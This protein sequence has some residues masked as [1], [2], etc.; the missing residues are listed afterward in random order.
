MQHSIDAESVDTH[1]LYHRISLVT[2]AAFKRI[3]HNGLGLL[4]R[5]N[6]THCAILSIAAVAF[7][8]LLNNTE[9]LSLLDAPAHPVRPLSQVVQLHML[10]HCLVEADRELLFR[11]IGL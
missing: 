4:V 11:E 9:L 5:H 1:S 3:E 6:L 7:L 8:H 10:Q 2:L